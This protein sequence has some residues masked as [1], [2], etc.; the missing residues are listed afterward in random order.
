MSAGVLDAGVPIGWLLGGHRSSRR[1][2][3]LFRS[4]REGKASLTISAVNL[5]EVF[6][7]MSEYARATG[8]DLLLL[9]RT[10]G[11]K[12]HA[13]DEE[14]ARRAAALPLSLA[15]AFAASTAQQLGARLHTTDSEMVRRL[16]PTRL[17]I[18]HY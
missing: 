12:V 8:A 18:T 17:P 7:H 1:L 10:C 13:P 6:K 4:G 14:I 9:L 2:D 16:R 15:D 3:A 5:A 11:V